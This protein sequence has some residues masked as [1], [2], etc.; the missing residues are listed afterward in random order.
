MYI[1]HQLPGSNFL[2]KAALTPHRLIK[3]DSVGMAM[4]KVSVVDTHFRMY[5]HLN[6]RRQS[7]LLQWGELAQHVTGAAYM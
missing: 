4:A 6:D 2:V 1:K 7:A 3:K 5:P